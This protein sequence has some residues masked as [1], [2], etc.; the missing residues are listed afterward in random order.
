MRDFIL[1]VDDD[2]DIRDA[3]IDLLVM[4]GYCVVGV[5]NGEQALGALAVAVPALVLTDVAMPVRDGLELALIIRESPR[6]RTVP[7]CFLTAA[8]R[9]TL[10]FGFASIRKPF[11][12]GELLE[13]VKHRVDPTVCLLK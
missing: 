9:A 12:A 5:E 8:P 2:A 6:L 13:I 11:D 4:N 10:P 7:V 1:V 3:V